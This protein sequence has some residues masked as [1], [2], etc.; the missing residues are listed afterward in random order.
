MP[1]WRGIF[2]GAL[3][4]LRAPAAASQIAFPPGPG[5]RIRV[6]STRFSANPYAGPTIVT[7][8]LLEMRDDS[9]VLQLDGRPPAA[10][11]TTVPLSAVTRLAVR[12]GRRPAVAEGAGVGVAVGLVGGLV[13]ALNDKSAEGSGNGGNQ[14]LSFPDFGGLQKASEII[15][16]GIVGG[17]LGAGVGS[18]FSTD[19]WVPISSDR[20]RVSVRPGGGPG[21]VSVGLRVALRRFRS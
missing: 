11:P 10:L 1:V 13:V 2:L 17:V 16:G 6:T 5:T 18:L 14:A 15:V 3:F 19:R 21:V 9:L 12:Q 7:A 20:L 8:T 4:G